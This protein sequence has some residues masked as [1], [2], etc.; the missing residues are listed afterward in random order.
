[1]AR[2]AAGRVARAAIAWA[3][4]PDAALSSAAGEL[5]VEVR[6]DALERAGAAGDAAERLGYLVAVRRE[7]RERFE[8][9]ARGLR[10]RWIGETIRWR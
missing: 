4:S 6:S 10:A 3:G 7:D 8:E 2:A 5:C 1:M 9:T